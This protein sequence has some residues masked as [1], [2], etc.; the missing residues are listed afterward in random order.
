[1]RQWT[2]RLP[3]TVYRLFAAGSF[4]SLT[5]MIIMVSI[6]VL[7]RFFLE[8][9]PHWT[10]EAARMFFVY[11]VAFGTGT[12]ISNGDFIR[13]DLLGKYITPATGRMLEFITSL[14]IILLSVVMVIHSFKFVKFGMAEKSPALQIS[15][16]FVFF[17]M[18]ITGTAIFIFTLAG[19]YR[20]VKGINRV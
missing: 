9:T 17:S 4:L 14:S 12:G 10:E 8:S 5:G 6:Q 19:L 16:G 15:M 20:S 18:V 3:E 1:M 7:S 11:A 2:D 13:L